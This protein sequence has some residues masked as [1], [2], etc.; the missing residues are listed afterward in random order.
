[1]KDISLSSYVYFVLCELSV[2]SD[3]LDSLSSRLDDDSVKHLIDDI[4]SDI[5][6]AINKLQ[7]LSL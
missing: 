4:S 1:M 2:A 5:E 3:N 6:N 7:N